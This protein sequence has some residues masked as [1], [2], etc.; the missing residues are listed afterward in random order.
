LPHTVLGHFEGVGAAVPGTT[1]D[2]GRCSE[3][4]EVVLF[5]TSPPSEGSHTYF[6]NA[7]GTDGLDHA[8]VFAQ[9]DG[10]YDVQ[11][12]DI[13]DD[14]FNADYD[15]NDV[16]LNIACTPDPIPTPEFPTMALPAALIVGLIG[17]ILFIKSTR[18]N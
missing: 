5:I 16:I 7:A 1:Y 17:A 11:F 4:T 8:H 13:D 18:E 12:E 2:V 14:L 9:V 15:F 10:S 3:D 6:S